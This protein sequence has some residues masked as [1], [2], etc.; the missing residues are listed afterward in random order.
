[1]EKAITG[2]NVG[3]NIARVSGRTR[4]TT[5]LRKR[6]GSPGRGYAPHKGHDCI[7]QRDSGDDSAC[8]HRDGTVPLVRYVFG[9]WFY[10]RTSN[11]AAIQVN[12]F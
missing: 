2:V 4:L 8:K 7:L 12:T 10:F 9:S 3:R 1:M 5:P 11:D 6:Q